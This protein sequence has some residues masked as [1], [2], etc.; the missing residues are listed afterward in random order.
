MTTK[1][2][3]EKLEKFAQYRADQTKD[4]TLHSIIEALENLKTLHQAV[5][6]GKPTSGNDYL[7]SVNKIV[8]NIAALEILNQDL[9]AIKQIQA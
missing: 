9:G 8:A 7:N 6:N 3:F 5:T 2:K 4:I 1:T